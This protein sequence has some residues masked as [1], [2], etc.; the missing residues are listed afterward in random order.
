M[1][2]PALFDVPL[3]A[4]L[5]AAVTEDEPCRF[6]HTPYNDGILF[7]CPAHVNG[8]LDADIEYEVAVFRRPEMVVSHAKPPAEC[9]V[10]VLQVQAQCC[11]SHCVDGRILRL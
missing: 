1:F 4:M 2:G 11:I 5:I 8:V 9:E 3:G 7:M 6:S 10:P